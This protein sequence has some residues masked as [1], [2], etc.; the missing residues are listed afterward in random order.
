[1]TQHQNFFDFALCFSLRRLVQVVF[2]RLNCH[3][4]FFFCFNYYSDFYSSLKLLYVH[5]MIENHL[6]DDWKFLIYLSVYSYIFASVIIFIVCIYINLY[7]FLRFFFMS[8]RI[9]TRCAYN[10]FI[11]EFLDSNST[12]VLNLCSSLFINLPVYSYILYASYMLHNT[13]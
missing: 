1:M 10:H 9:C 4:F 7:L 6:I 11:H 8:Q 2:F 13:C 12:C 3:H 5:Q